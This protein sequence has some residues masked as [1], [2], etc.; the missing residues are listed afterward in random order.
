MEINPAIVV[1][2]ALALVMALT[3][4]DVIKSTGDTYINNMPENI[5]KYKIIAWMIVLIMI[6]IIIHHVFTPTKSTIDDV[7]PLYGMS[8]FIGGKNKIV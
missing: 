1:Q 2:S 5:V 7:V 6:Y 3:T 8:S 4:I